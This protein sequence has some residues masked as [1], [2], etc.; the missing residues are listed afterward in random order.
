MALTSAELR[1]K[2]SGELEKMLTQLRDELQQMRFDLS[3]GR[4]K[5]IREIRDRKRDIARIQTVLSETR[6]DQDEE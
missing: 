2:K 5:N 4:V 6:L 3:A 1:T